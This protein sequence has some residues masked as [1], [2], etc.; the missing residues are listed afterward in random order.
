[1]LGGITPGLI[2]L[3]ETIDNRK[4]MLDNSTSLNTGSCNTHFGLDR[5]SENK[6]RT[7]SC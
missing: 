5:V 1:M 4:K 3:E 7:T 6:I 2:G